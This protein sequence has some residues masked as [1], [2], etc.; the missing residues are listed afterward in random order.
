MR[1]DSAMTSS[2]AF[3]NRVLGAA[4]SVPVVGLLMELLF[5]REE[6]AHTTRGALGWEAPAVKNHHWLAI[7]PP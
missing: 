6:G 7:I 2:P 5:V 1:S 3:S 4:A